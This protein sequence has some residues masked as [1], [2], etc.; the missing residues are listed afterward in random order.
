[1]S[2]A[3]FTHPPTTVP[4]QWVIRRVEKND[5]W[6]ERIRDDAPVTID[7]RA[8]PLELA[9]A[10]SDTFGSALLFPRVTDEEWSS[11]QA[12][13]LESDSFSAWD[14]DRCVGHAGSFRFDT[15]VPGG[16][17]LSTAGVT[18]VGVLPTYTRRGLLTS[19]MRELLSSVRSS[20]TV[21]ATLRASEATI[22]KRFGYGIAA[23]GASVRITSSAI[24]AVA[25]PAPGTHRI[26]RHDELM[27]VLPP[28]YE[29][30][31]RRRVGTISRPDFMWRR[32]LEDALSGAKPSFVVVHD[33]EDGVSDGYV[34]YD[35][36]WREA[37]EVAPEV[38][39]GEV[40]DLWGIDASVERALWAYLLGI[41][42]VV[43]WSA[44][45]RPIDEA[46]RFAVP[47]TRAYKL[48]DR[49][50]EQW[51]RILDVDAALTARTYGPCTGAVTIEVRDPWFEENNGTW[52]ID[53]T[54]AQRSSGGGSPAALVVDIATVSAAYL[55]GT[56]WRELTDAGQV[57]SAD[58]T[59]AEPAADVVATADALFAQRPA[60]FCGSFY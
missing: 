29:Q 53:A 48:R 8:T 41:D 26:L 34:H 55:G 17:R 16:A 59:D 49:W 12:S 4:G 36:K 9:R 20:G 11:R 42:L 44:D 31:G 33:N 7:I 18:R 57:L 14:D 13:W 54:G 39:V 6:W 35:V 47:N 25:A 2:D 23:E 46:L 10:A 15:S 1:M 45:E 28:L 5:A 32:Y 40:N 22:Y 60:P 30:C 24:G 3:I 50:D 27:T 43:E 19:M 51:L 56:S 21:L 52:R 37:T 38:G 58:G